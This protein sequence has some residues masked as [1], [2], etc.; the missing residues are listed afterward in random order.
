MGELASVLDSLAGDDVH[1]I[2]ELALL[3]RT[4]TLLTARNRLDAEIARS[5]Q[6]SD[7]RQVM[8]THCG[9]TTKSWLV[10][11]Q[12][13]GSDEAARRMKV[14][15]L[16]P[17]YPVLAA[18]LAAGEISHEHARVILG[19]LR[20]LP[21]SLHDAAA[22]ELTEAA[23]YADPGSLGR[24]C[25]E[26]RARMGVEDA[27][28]AAQR[29]YASR[30]VTTSHTLDGMLHIEGM[31]DPESGATLTAALTPLMHRVGTEDE[32]TTGQRRADALT[33]LARFSLRDGG[34]PDHN[35]ERPHVMVT[36]PWSELQHGIAAGQLPQARLNGYEITP[37]TAR[38]L[39]CD[40]DII[41]AVLGGRGE[42]LDLGRS[43]RLFSRAQRRARAVEDGGCVWPKC[44]AG[45]ERCHVHHLDFWWRGGKT[46]KD[47][48]ANLCS[49][50]H[51]LAHHSDW[52][53]RRNA[54][55][56]IEVRRT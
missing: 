43:S 1:A 41:P 46:D 28:E 56:K 33:D 6:A 15:R 34:L 55:G 24:L 19:C 32:R 37:E 23:T 31:L 36:I 16:L 29:R 51:W 26:I 35:G 39:A 40:A 4:E 2:P 42:I 7:V 5:L 44:Q 21:S 50:H 49:F 10:E 14:A 52:T 20:G 9:R 3:D 38:R 18:A 54:A 48:G 13:L 12:L 8:T 25:R 11:E 17:Y 53:V 47:N 45:L 27:E 30:W 22:A